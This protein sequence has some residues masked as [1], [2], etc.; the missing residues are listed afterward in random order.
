MSMASKQPYHPVTP[1]SPIHAMKLIS[2][3][4]QHSRGIKIPEL[5]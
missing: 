1:P 5:V 4:R 3:P 2:S